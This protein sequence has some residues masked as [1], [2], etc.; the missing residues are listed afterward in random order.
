MLYVY[1]FLFEKIK[2]KRI[3]SQKNMNF[4]IGIITAVIAIVTL[5]N[6]IKDL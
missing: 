5:I 6:I 1:V 2:S 4:S 3:K